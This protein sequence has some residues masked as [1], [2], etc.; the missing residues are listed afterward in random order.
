MKV[1]IDAALINNHSV[2]VTQ[3]E[4]YLVEMSNGCI[5]CTLREDLLVEVKKIASS[6]Q[7]DYLLIEST[8]VSEPLPVAETFSFEDDT[9][10]KLGDIASIDT[11]VTVIDGARFLSELDSLHSLRERDWHADPE[12]QRT[13]S[14][15]LCDQVEFAN[16]KSLIHPSCSYSIPSIN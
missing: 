3:K 14:H 7:F 10:E 5:C 4:E 15:L 6:G 2:S 11:M 13:I 8:G 9:G 16:G 12:D 1:N